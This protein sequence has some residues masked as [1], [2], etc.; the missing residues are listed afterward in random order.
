MSIFLPNAE[1]I[2][3]DDMVKHVYQADGKLRNKVTTRTGVVGKQYEFARMGDG[4]ANQK[5]IQAD[6]TPMNV[7]HGRQIAVL[8]DWNAD[9]YTDIFS[10]A[11]VNYDEKSELAQTCGK[12][13]RRREDQ[14]IIN[15]LNAITTATT[16]DTNPDTGLAIDNP[17]GT[18]TSIFTLDKMRLAAEHF[19]D[20]EVDESER[21]LLLTAKAKRQ[22]LEDTEVTSSDFN[23]IKALVNG[24]LNTY[25]GFDIVTLGS[26]KEGG[27]P[28]NTGTSTGTAF[29]FHKAAIGYAVGTI[30]MMTEID[31][32]AQK[33]AWLTACS[34]SSGAVARE[35]Q[36]IVKI[37]F[38]TNA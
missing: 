22:L 20:L 21:C 4:I 25:M 18:A 30:D 28:L 24:E 17:G 2:A 11:K 5:A 8:S 3:F 36:G 12:A 35:A 27:L 26:R 38:L 7:D 14:T 31:W 34:L 10:N 29:A 37:G 19:D 15:A 9:E 23:T 1:V 32:I 13:L 33:K 16:N 6:V